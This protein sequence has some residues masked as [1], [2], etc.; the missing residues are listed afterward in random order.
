[1]AAR[2]RKAEPDQEGKFVFVGTIKKLRASTMKNIPITDRTAVVRVDQIIESPRLLS[3]YT[4]KDITVQL[5]VGRK[6]AV[7]S[8]MLFRTSGWIFGDSVAVRSVSQEPVGAAHSALLGRSGDPTA[9][10][11]QRELSTHFSDAD[12][13]VSGRVIRIGVPENEAEQGRAATGTPG[14][15]GPVSEHDPMWREA[16]VEVDQVHKGLRTKEPIVVRF[17]SSTDVRW[18]RA[19]KFSPGQQG[20]FILHRAVAARQRPGAA[21]VA[22][23]KPRGGEAYVALHPLDFQPYDQPGGIKTLIGAGHNSHGE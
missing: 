1:M 14:P 16:V 23:P 22:R 3:H 6:I 18:H 12:A 5:S 21:R 2:V 10:F 15:Q 19:P 13:V 11:H 4:G 9:H 20:Y 8:K 17:P 7:G